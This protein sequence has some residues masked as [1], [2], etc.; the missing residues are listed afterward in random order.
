LKFKKNNT[1]KLKNMKSLFIAMAISLLVLAGCE[2]TE[3]PDKQTIVLVH[4]A[5]SD[6]SAWDEVK[7]LLTAK[8]LNVITVNLPGHGKDTTAFP[9]ITLQSYVDAVEKAIGTEKNVILVGHSMA[10][11]VISQVAEDMSGNIK[12]LIYLSAY[13]P[14]NGQSLLDIAKT[15]AGSHVGKY[16]NIDEGTASAAIDKEGAVDIFVADGPKSVQEKFA[17]GVRPDPLVPF[18]TPVKLT[19]EHFGAAEKVY[20]YTTNDHAVSYPAQQA[21][22][23]ATQVKT[24]YTL[25]SSHTPFYSMPDKLAGILIKEAD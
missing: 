24:E 2:K 8:G 17:K 14:K 22:V 21:M 5:W 12:K 10:G 16:L 11:I 9:S 23:K 3:Y 13:L 20:I 18:V 7:P 25:Q 6:V 15:D 4:G 1:L 19:A